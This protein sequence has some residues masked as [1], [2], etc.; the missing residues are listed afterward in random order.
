MKDVQ[1]INES[2]F[3]MKK[4]RGVCKVFVAFSGV[5]C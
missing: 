5:I 2:N 4:T 1:F 3:S